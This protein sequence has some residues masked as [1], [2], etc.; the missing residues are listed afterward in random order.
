[1]FPDNKAEKGTPG[2]A[3]IAIIDIGAFMPGVIAQYRQWKRKAET[4]PLEDDASEQHTKTQLIAELRRVRQRAIEWQNL[5]D[6]E[7]LTQ[8]LPQN[9]PTRYS[10]RA[11]FNVFHMILLFMLL[12]IAN[13]ESD[14]TTEAELRPFIIAEETSLVLHVVR[15]QELASNVRTAVGKAVESD[16]L[17]AANTASLLSRMIELVLS[18]SQEAGLAQIR[19]IMDELVSDLTYARRPIGFS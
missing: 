13:E 7:L 10:A 18:A 19:R 14:S 11:A 1:M 2:A 17:A 6:T 5:Y 3:Y 4:V 15:F 8:T 12:S 9:F 16:Q